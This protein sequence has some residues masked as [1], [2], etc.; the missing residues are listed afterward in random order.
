MIWDVAAEGQDCVQAALKL[1]ERLATMPTTALV[2]TR[3]L[4]R[5]A[6]TNELDTQL[7][8]ERDTQSGLG[9]THDYIEGVMAFREKRPAQF[10]GE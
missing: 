6:A 2:Q 4:L 8:L 7:D 5:A 9:K 1:A 3:K 10:T